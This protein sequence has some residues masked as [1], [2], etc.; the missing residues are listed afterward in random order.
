MEATTKTVE[1]RND[2][3]NTSCCVRVPAAAGG[4]L[5]HSQQRRAERA[6][7][8]MADCLCGVLRGEQDGIPD[9]WMV[10]TYSSDQWFIG[11]QG[12]E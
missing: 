10:D 6:L 8:G 2:F 11:P 12:D 5:T 1:L 9:G 3:H 7:C 4:I